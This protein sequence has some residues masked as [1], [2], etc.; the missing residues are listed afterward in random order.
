MRFVDRLA[1]DPLNA[2]LHFEYALHSSKKG[3]AELAFAELKTAAFLGACAGQV[4]AR[5]QEFREAVPA[6]EEM[7]H[8]QFYRF[9]SLRSAIAKWSKR[10]NPS[11]L[12]I[13]GGQGKL[14]SFIPESDYCLAE[15]TVNG[16]S[17]IALPFADRSF[18]L[19]VACHVLE[20][21]PVEHR[22]LFLDQ[23]LAKARQ[24][25]ILLNPFHVEGSH[26]DERLEL[27]V[28]VTNARWAQ[29]HLECTLPDVGDVESYAHDRG[30][31]IDVE[32]N[33][34]LTTSMVLVFMDYFAAQAKMDGKWKAVNRFLNTKC[35]EMLDSPAAPNAF[36]VYLARPEE[37]DPAG[38]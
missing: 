32:P 5:E 10:D 13:G 20:H 7:S 19:V 36:T 4:Q 31:Q 38:W 1:E 6:P 17:G 14:A 21:V 15:P 22:R 25:V 34:T 27:F 23:M 2:A 3:K 11:V 30:L 12:D 16:I 35:M 29:E 26:V 18:D 8:N 33:G 28:E 9:S 24:G 37:P